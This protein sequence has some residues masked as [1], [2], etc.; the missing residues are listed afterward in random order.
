MLNSVQLDWY[1]T[2]TELGKNK[3]KWGQTGKIGANC[4]PMGQKFA[5]QD[6]EDQMVKMNKM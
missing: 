3:A 5:N 4:G 1:W 2:G 6:K